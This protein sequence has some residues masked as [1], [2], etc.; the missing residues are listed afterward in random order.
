MC[1]GGD[2]DK[3]PVFTGTPNVLECVEADLTTFYLLHD[4]CR[5]SL[6]NLCQL[7]SDLVVSQVFH[8]CFQS[9]ASNLAQAPQLFD[10]Q[11]VQ[12]DVVE[13]AGLVGRGCDD[14]LTRT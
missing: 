3:N 14:W 7:S 1:V 5:L 2:R 9:F 6:G 13:E 4:H 11:V 8:L 12:L 10:A